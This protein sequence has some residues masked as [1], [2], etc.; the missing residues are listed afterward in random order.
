MS[1]R[2]IFA[3]GSI[4]VDVDEGQVRVMLAGES[5]EISADIRRRAT[6]VQKRAQR[7]APYRTGTLRHSIHVNTRYP[8]DGAAADIVA[9]APYAAAVEFGRRR[10]EARPGSALHWQGRFEGDK[11]SM[12]AG[13]V[14]GVH[15]MENALDA[16]V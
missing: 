2:T 4:D 3:G 6:A 5:G 12:W 16:V 7:A 13:P 1:R 14:A 11:F 9:D 15:F 8:S 10:S